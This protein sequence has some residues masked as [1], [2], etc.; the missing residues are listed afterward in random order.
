MQLKFTFGAWVLGC[1]LHLNAQSQIDSLRMPYDSLNQANIPSGILLEWSGH[2]AGLG[3]NLDRFNGNFNSP[4]LWETYYMGLYRLFYLAQMTPQLNHPGLYDS[5]TFFEE[6]KPYDIPIGAFHLNYQRIDS[7]AIGNGTI[8]FDTSNQKYYDVPGMNPYL[9]KRVFASAQFAGVIAPDFVTHYHTEPDPNDPTKILVTELATFF[10]SYKI[11]TSLFFTND[12]RP[13]QRIKIDFANDSGFVEVPQNTPVIIPYTIKKNDPE[14]CSGPHCLYTI[15]VRLYYTEGNGVDSLES[16]FILPISL[17]AQADLTLTSDDLNL[18]ST[19]TI[20][21]DRPPTKAKYHILFGQGRLTIQKPIVFIEGFDLGM[22]PYGNLN[23]AGFRTG[24]FTDGEGGTD[25]APNL[26]LMPHLLDTL[27][28]KGYDVIIVDHK[29][30][31]EFIE[32][33]AGATIKLIQWLN[34]ELQKNGSDEEIVVLGASMGGLIARYAIRK[35][36]IDGC[37][38]NVRMYGTFDS[39]HGS[40]NIPLGIQ[41]MVQTMAYRMPMSPAFEAMRRAY[42]YGLCSPGAVQM[43]KYHVNNYNPYSPSY[44]FGDPK[45]WNYNPW[46]ND[47]TNISFQ[48]IKDNW[49]HLLD[50]IGHPQNAYKIAVVNGSILGTQQPFPQGALLFDFMIDIDAPIAQPNNFT[51]WPIQ[52]MKAFA[53]ST[54]S[55]NVIL[56]R[57]GGFVAATSSWYYT[58]N[59]ISYLTGIPLYLGSFGLVTEP[60]NSMMNQWHNLNNQLTSTHHQNVSLLPYDNCAGSTANTMLEIQGQFIRHM[61]WAFQN[62]MSKQDKHSFVAT[63]SAL[64]L[65]T[66]ILNLQLPSKIDILINKK[67]I[68]F[69]EVW[70]PKTLNSRNE[71]TDSKNQIH[72]Q[73]TQENLAWIISK[74]EENENILSVADS[75][76]LHKNLKTVFNFGRKN[77]NFIKQL[78]IDNGGYCLVNNYYFGFDFSGYLNGERPLNGSSFNL[79]TSESNCNGSWV[80][81]KSNGTFEIGSDSTTSKVKISKGTFIEIYSGG[82]L[83]I[84]NHSVLIIEPGA[85]LIIHPGANIVLNGSDAVLELQGDVNLMQDAIFTFQGSGFVR[86]AMDHNQG[87]AWNLTNNNRFVLRGSNKQ[88]KVLEVVTATA[89]NQF[90]EVVIARGNVA[91]AQPVAMHIGSSVRLDTALFAPIDTLTAAA[92]LGFFGVLLEGSLN[93][94]VRHSRFVN[95]QFGLANNGLQGYGV[96]IENSTFA[97]CSTGVRLEGPGGTITGSTFKENTIGLDANNITLEVGVTASNFTDN[98]HLGIWYSGSDGNAK[99]TLEDCYLANNSYSGLQSQNGT[100]ISK[101]TDFVQNGQYGIIADRNRVVLRGT[102]M[103]NNPEAFTG[104]GIALLDINSGY[105]AFINS[106]SGNDFFAQLDATYSLLFTNSFKALKNSVSGNISIHKITGP[107]TVT[108]S[109]PASPS[110]LLTYVPVLCATNLPITRDLFGNLSTGLDDIGTGNN[111]CDSCRFYVNSPVVAA[112]TDIYNRL[113]SRDPS[114][115]LEDIERAD[116]IASIFEGKSLTAPES[117]LRDYALFAAMEALSAAFSEGLLEAGSDAQYTDMVLNRLQAVT[118]DTTAAGTE[119]LFSNRIGQALMMRL[120]HRYDDALNLLANHSAFAVT[121][122]QTNQALY[123]QCALEGER[124]LLNGTMSTDE[125]LVW[126]ST[127]SQTFGMRTAP[128]AFEASPVTYESLPL[129]MSIFPNPAGDY[130]NFRWTEPVTGTLTI[131]DLRGRPV[132]EPWLLNGTESAHVPLHLPTGVYL[133]LVQTEHATLTT[134]KLV[135]H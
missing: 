126:N 90:E 114:G 107:L 45:N 3:Y 56:E 117:M 104:S 40:A 115:M 36:E 28:A 129:E 65:D 119:R 20:N 15:R 17:V 112:L 58:F 2:Q 63:I 10:L 98:N 73:M 88:D 39:P 11:P 128:Q 74:I 19:C 8:G 24:K 71:I 76:T 106:S 108:L 94:H 18:D 68:P 4:P 80:R 60:S 29:N 109:P 41:K 95:A 5:L 47:L 127:C 120:N 113:E 66:N 50:S 67:K 131:T 53:I 31:R 81:I 101:C 52:G 118:F 43:L 51:N 23:W 82:N 135:V 89:L 12:A 69:N 59:M 99:L 92:Q 111:G 35:M 26:N 125:F 13:L 72:V 87:A 85:Q 14:R 75:G 7:N 133:V 83:I 48:S 132:A 110:G 93:Q 49:D 123:W 97:R 77:R 25:I 44:F 116:E 38:H 6:E 124:D 134:Q 84:N 32:S 121:P 55:S 122:V 91:F 64:D 34:K 46:R 102:Y 86:Y 16:R 57:R 27:V 103:S 37:C 21:Y 54:A 22:R 100:F 33:N 42:E 130:A 62:T 61:G 1:V 30:G 96:N 105:N 70:Y 9:N 79:A 78:D